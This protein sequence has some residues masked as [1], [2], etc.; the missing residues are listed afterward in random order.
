MTEKVV[1]SNP[2]LDAATTALRSLAIASHRDAEPKNPLE[3]GKHLLHV[4]QHTVGN[5]ER[6]MFCATLNSLD[7]DRC[8]TLVGMRLMKLGPWIN[9]R[10]DRY[11][12]ATQTGKTT[13]ATLRALFGEEP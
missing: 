9:E 7:F 11:F 13:A 1:G 2:S 10:Q 5:G 8:M 4:L 3:A 12:Y 6:N